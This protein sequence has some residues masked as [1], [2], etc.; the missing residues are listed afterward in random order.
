MFRSAGTHVPQ[1]SQQR[2][3][4]GAGRHAYNIPVVEVAGFEADDVIGTL[5]SMAEKE[6]YTTYMMSPDKDFGQLVTPRIIQYKPSY[7]GQDFE[8]RGPEEV[9]QR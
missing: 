5:S 1:G 7:R 4:V 2:I 8:L 3:Q 6:G 9:C